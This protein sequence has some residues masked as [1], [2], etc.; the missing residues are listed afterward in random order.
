VVVLAWQRDNYVQK[1]PKGSNTCY[2]LLIPADL[3]F[4]TLGQIFI[5]KYYTGT[6]VI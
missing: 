6:C 5:N 1:D 2:I 3:G 4:W